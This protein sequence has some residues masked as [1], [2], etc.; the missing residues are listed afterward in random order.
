M[1]ELRAIKL[2]IQSKCVSWCG[3]CIKMFST[4]S[5]VLQYWK[6][7]IVRVFVWFLPHFSPLLALLLIRP[8]SLSLSLAS[9]LYI[10]RLSHTRIMHTWDNINHFDVLSTR[11]TRATRRTSSI[12]DCGVT[13]YYLYYVVYSG[14]LFLFFFSAAK[15]FRT[16]CCATNTF[17]AEVAYWLITS[18]QSLAIDTSFFSPPGLLNG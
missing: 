6:L 14:L 17:M 13:E 11:R 15:L 9:P 7:F 1:T 8:L 18:W 5:T 2:Y 10:S 12:C 3:S 16:N 4:Y